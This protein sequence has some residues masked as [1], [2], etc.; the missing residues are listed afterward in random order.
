M[1]IPPYMLV[2]PDKDDNDNP[3]DTLVFC[4]SDVY[5]VYA[6]QYLLQLRQNLS[7]TEAFKISKSGLEFTQSSKKKKWFEGA[8][9]FNL[10][11]VYFGK[12]IADLI[13]KNQSNKVSIE[14]SSEKTNAS[15]DPRLKGV[16]E[17]MENHTIDLFKNFTST[18]NLSDMCTKMLPVTYNS[19]EDTLILDIKKKYKIG[20]Y[21]ELFFCQILKRKFGDKFDIKKNWITSNRL[22][23]FPQFGKENINDS[24]GCDFK[25]KDDKGFLSDEPKTCFIEV[26]GCQDWDGT[27]FFTQ[28]E[29][30]KFEFLNLFYTIYIIVAVV[31]N[32]EEKISIQLYH[33]KY[34]YE[35]FNSKFSSKQATSTI[36]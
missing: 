3:S 1:E 13:D 2:L 35:T 20:L 5:F 8:K 10:K 32:A 23:A 6:L 11:R 21:A 25:V 17:T 19:N 33:N 30:R 18:S 28:N 4:S 24:F 36:N 7:Q 31:G 27:F 34:F 16:W 29:L 15:L 22:I 14:E 26:K 9:N 12:E